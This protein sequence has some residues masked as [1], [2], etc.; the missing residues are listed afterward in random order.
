[1]WTVRPSFRLYLE[2]TWGTLELNQCRYNQKNKKK[3]FA[4]CKVG[5]AR[6]AR[7]FSISR[8]GYVYRFVS[9]FMLHEF[10]YLYN[11]QVQL[12]E[13]TSCSKTPPQPTLLAPVRKIQVLSKSWKANWNDYVQ[14]Y[15]GLLD[16]TSFWHSSSGMSDDFLKMQIAKKKLHS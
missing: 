3:H 4:P 6:L 1:M 12:W 2:S 16:Q 13:A 9:C 8:D 11:V 5:T 10:L 14:L 15:Y 7:L